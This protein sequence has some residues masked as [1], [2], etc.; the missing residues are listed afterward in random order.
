MS[1]GENVES[2]E[3]NN[4]GYK[5]PPRHTRFKKGQSGNP[6]GR[7]KGHLNLKTD[8]TNELGERIRLNQD[9][10]PVKL[11]KQQALVKS[12]VARAI[13]GDPRA[14]GVLF[15]LILRVFDIEPIEEADKAPLSQS[16]ELILKDFIAGL[17]KN[18]GEE[19]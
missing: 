3:E 1:D 10:K 18:E 2:S 12:L 6:K 17:G 16:D 14:N 11:T 4:V 9:G 13:K 15:P 5:R 8:L 19:K 7:P